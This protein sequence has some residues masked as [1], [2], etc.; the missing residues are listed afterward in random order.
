MQHLL[1]A[2]VDTNFGGRSVGIIRLRTTATEFSLA[3]YG[4]LFIVFVCLVL[5]MCPIF[6]DILSE[7]KPSYR[8]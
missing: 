1:P 3:Y 8:A 6:V 2:K 5:Y 7:T 4:I